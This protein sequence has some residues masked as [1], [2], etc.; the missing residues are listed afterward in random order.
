MSDRK[1]IA[2]FAAF[3][4]MVH[5]RRILD[6]ILSRC[7]A[8]DYDI[9]VFASSTHLS[10]PHIDYMRGE[11]N[12]YELANLDKFDGV[13]VDHGSMTDN[14]DN[15]SLKRLEERL[16]AYPDLP[17]CSLEMSLKGMKLIKKDNED[18][19]REMCRHVIE[20]HGRKKICILTGPADNEVAVE[21]LKIFLDEIEKGMES[22]G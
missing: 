21:R 17:K 11:S 5:V 19:L 1:R 7:E 9:C 14:K 15:R 3:P 22:V 2:L 12:I 10:F 8:Y 18:V 4:E 13:I 16:Q 20:K 6:G